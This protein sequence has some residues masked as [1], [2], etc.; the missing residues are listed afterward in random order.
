[1]NPELL[2]ELATMAIDV[3]RQVNDNLDDNYIEERLLELIHQ[4]V[5]AYEEH[6][7]VPFDPSLIHAEATF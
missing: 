1:M 3:A 2:F 4:G 5:D 6:T 7:G